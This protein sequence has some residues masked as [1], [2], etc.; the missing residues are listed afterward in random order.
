VLAILLIAV[1]L[2]I[3]MGDPSVKDVDGL[4]KLEKIASGSKDALKG[5]SKDDLK[6][7]TKGQAG[8]PK[9]SQDL[10]GWFFWNGGK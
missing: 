7:L 10:I 1:G 3:L 5:L 8:A 9:P 4:K 6:R 2:M